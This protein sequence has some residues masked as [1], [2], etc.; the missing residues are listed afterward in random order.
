MFIGVGVSPGLHSVDV[1]NSFRTTSKPWLKPLI[2][3]ICGGIE[4]FPRDS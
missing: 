3:G 2:I 4:S 1:Q